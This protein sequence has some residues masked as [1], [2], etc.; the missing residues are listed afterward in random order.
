MPVWMIA[1]LKVSRSTMAAQSRGSVNVFVQPENDA[2]EAMATLFFRR[3]YR[4]PGPSVPE[5]VTPGLCRAACTGL[6]R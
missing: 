4:V 3:S 2:L 6:C 1:S 5:R